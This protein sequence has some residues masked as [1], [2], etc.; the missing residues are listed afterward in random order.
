MKFQKAY[1]V[2][3]EHI[4]IQ[5]IVDGLYYPFYME[6][7]RHDY[8]NKVLGFDLAEEAKLGVNMVLSEYHISFIRSLKR[9]DEFIVDCLLI[10]DKDNLPKLH[11]QQSILCNNKIMTKALFTGTCVPAAGGKP[12]LPTTIIE[13]INSL[14]E[15]NTTE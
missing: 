15:K 4:D 11:F 10:A 7:C 3:D 13:K 2:K 6:D 8:I 12:F 1:K 14:T 9:D 5:G